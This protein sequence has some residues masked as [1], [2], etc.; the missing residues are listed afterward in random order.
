M[1]AGGLAAVPQSRILR[2]S[3][4]RK[5]ES[6]MLHTLLVPGPLEPGRWMASRSWGEEAAYDRDVG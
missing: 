5:P 1:T 3:R 6:T 2:T 4:T